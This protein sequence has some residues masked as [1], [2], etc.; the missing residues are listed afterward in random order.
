MA[1]RSLLGGDSEDGFE[2]VYR[3]KNPPLLSQ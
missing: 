2:S 1:E 3:P